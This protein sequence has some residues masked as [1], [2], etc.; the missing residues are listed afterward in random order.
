MISMYFVNSKKTVKGSVNEGGIR[1]PSIATWPKQI[2]A[3]SKSDHP[4]TF[5]DYFATVSDIIGEAPPYEIDGI[6]YYPTLIGKKQMAHE[7]LYWE[8]PAYGGQQA[9]RI[10]QWKGIKKDLFKGSSDLQLF[11]IEDDP[12]ELN[13]LA[14]NYPDIVKKMERYMDQAHTEAQ[15]EKFKIPVLDNKN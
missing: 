5:Y 7:Y 13:N 15:M 9:I 10:N 2:K 3:G 6:S 14:S 12:K 8:F 11:N 1:V 4:S